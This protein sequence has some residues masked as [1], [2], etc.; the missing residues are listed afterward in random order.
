[1]TTPAAKCA[2]CAETYEPVDKRD[3]DRT[4]TCDRLRGH[5][6]AHHCPVCCEYW[7]GGVE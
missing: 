2:E 4:H 5:D 1:M 7:T 6:G 3:L